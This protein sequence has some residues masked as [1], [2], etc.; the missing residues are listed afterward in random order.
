MGYEAT[1][2]I[3]YCLNAAE[4]DEW[5]PAFRAQ[6]YDEVGQSVAEARYD[7]MEHDEF[8]E[9]FFYSEY[10]D[11]DTD[12]VGMYYHG[13]FVLGEDKGYYI[14]LKGKKKTA[15]LGDPV[16]INPMM[17]RIDPEDAAALKHAA[18]RM[19]IPVAARKIE[20]WMEVSLT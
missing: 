17:T 18:Q 11:I 16:I 13:D 14:Y 3:G 10:D 9:H 12:R 6:V 20:L 4:F 5:Y 19:K 2:F 15:Y 1:A 8:L 7:D